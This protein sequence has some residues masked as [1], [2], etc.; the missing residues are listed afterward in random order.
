MAFPFAF[1]QSAMAIHFKSLRIV[2]ARS[3]SDEAIQN[4]T[5]PGLLRSARNDDTVSPT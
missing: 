4:G 2:I 3:I 5:P 1:G